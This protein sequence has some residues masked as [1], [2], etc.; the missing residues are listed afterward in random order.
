MRCPY[1]GSPVTVRGDFW[2]CGYC[3][4]SGFLPSRGGGQTEYTVSFHLVFDIDL[5]DT[6]KTMK[7]SVSAAAGRSAESLYSSMAM[8]FLYE[9]TRALSL[10]DRVLPTEKRRKLECFLRQTPEM[11]SVSAASEIM[12]AAD[13]RRILFREEGQLEDQACGGFWQKLTDSLPKEEDPELSDLFRGFG[14]VH[15]YFLSEECQNQAVD[16]MIELRDLFENHRSRGR[17]FSGNTEKA[18]ERLKKDD[19]SSFDEDC[20]DI[21]FSLMP[22]LFKEYTVQDMA[23]FGLAPNL[24][25][26][27]QRDPSLA[28]RAWKTLYRYLQSLGAAGTRVN[29]R[30]DYAKPD[31]LED[32]GL[33]YG[34]IR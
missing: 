19:T 14:N 33:G 4:D 5:S 21:L 17:Y 18:V 9:I 30:M 7:C 8:A 12:N 26:L 32:G 1:C 24:Y 16:R 23:D 15:Q 28:V 25:E 34:T 10:S 22:E 29:K 20:R 3:G 13:R 31:C 6:W 2:E 27:E 11:R